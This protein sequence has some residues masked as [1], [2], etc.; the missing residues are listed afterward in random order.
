[1]VRERPFFSLPLGT[2]GPG[3]RGSMARKMIEKDVC[4]HH[5]TR[6]GYFSNGL[7]RI[8]R[9][10]AKNLVAQAFQPVQKTLGFFR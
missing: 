2:L 4:H 6:C 5:L 7:A 9:Q 10:A 3:A 8:I 1:M